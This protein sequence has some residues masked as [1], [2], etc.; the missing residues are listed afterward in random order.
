MSDMTDRDVIAAW[1]RRRHGVERALHDGI[2][3]HL[4]A[5][6]VR[7]Q[8]DPDIE[9]TAAF[10]DSIIGDVRC[11]AEGRLPD[12]LPAGDLAAALAV[13][14]HTSP[15]RVTHD[16]TPMDVDGAV[17]EALVYVATEAIANCARHAPGADVHLALTPSEGRAVLVVSD[18][19]PGGAVIRSGGGLAG[20]AERI[21][22]LGGRLTVERAGDR[23]DV[24]VEIGAR[25]DAMPVADA[26]VSRRTRA[27]DRMV[28]ERLATR[29]IDALVEV[30]AAVVASDLEGAR[31]HAARALSEVR[32][33]VHRM[34]SD[35]ETP[36]LALA[37]LVSDAARRAGTRCEVSIDGAEEVD[38]WTT[39]LIAEEILHAVGPEGVAR[40]TLRRRHGQ[41][42]VR[43]R[44]ERLPLPSA[45][46][47]VEH[48]VAAADGSLTVDATCDDRVQMVVALP[49]SRPAPRD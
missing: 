38:L 4:V 19:G 27:L 34:R 18:G 22:V 26:G 48:A 13:I 29:P 3:Q 8:A 17:V 43:A 5:L 32:E 11:L 31:R 30:R 33:V 39:S 49:I 25:I 16:L 9:E 44:L 6:M 15:M 7:L 40:L 21:A 41:F 2:Q 46:A 42:E 20:L 1:A 28:S 47:V 10:V 12:A 36:E 14:A 24:T 37:S 45:I 35:T 23:T